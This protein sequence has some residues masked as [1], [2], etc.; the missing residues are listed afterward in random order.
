MAKSM[1]TT[2][3]VPEYCQVM[4]VRGSNGEMKE[5]IFPK[6]L[7]LDRPKR[8]RTTFSTY[9]LKTLEIEFDKNP[10]L[11]GTDR[12]FLAKKLN[13]TE[14]QVKVWYQN[15]RIKCKR[16]GPEIP[17]SSTHTSVTSDDTNNPSPSVANI[18]LMANWNSQSPNTTNFPQINPFACF[19]GQ[20]PFAFDQN[21]FFGTNNQF[22][23]STCSSLYNPTS[24][25]CQQIRH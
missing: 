16:K 6:A 13:L 19:P 21:S 23:S 1:Q 18:P 10:Y 7:D 24:N 25:I 3:N 14:T 2:N 20:L 12:I 11:V 9:Q 15:R 8:P 22:N 4:R 5:L 17:S